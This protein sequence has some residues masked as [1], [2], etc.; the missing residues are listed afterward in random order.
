MTKLTI[1]HEYSGMSDYWGGNGRRWEDD[2]GCLFAY[3][4][5]K[6]T[7]KD[8][9]EQWVDE[10]YTGGDCDSLPDDIT[11]D[12]LR[13][14]I[15]ENLTEQGRADYESGALAQCAA[16]YADC[17]DPLKC[18]VCGE[19]EGEQHLDNCDDCE[20]TVTAEDCD[21]YD[22][23]Q[24]SPVWI[25]LVEATVCSE[26]NK[27]DDHYVDDLCK[28]CSKKHYPSDFDENGDFIS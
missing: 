11:Q 13:N 23:C 18:P 25:I 21:E 1:R 2:A 26:C 16:Y 19:C 5:R 24:E 14:A 17:A 7:L 28:D 22:D 10:F 3:Y 12:D 8:C 4:D 9:V 27:W 6:T 20:G 15:L